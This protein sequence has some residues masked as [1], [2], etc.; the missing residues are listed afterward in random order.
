MQRKEISLVITHR[1]RIK[2]SCVS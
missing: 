1:Q 2:S